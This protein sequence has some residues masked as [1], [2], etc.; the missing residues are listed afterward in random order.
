MMRGMTNS[1]IMNESIRN[2]NEAVAKGKADGHITSS[3]MDEIIHS[4]N[5]PIHGK[6]PKAAEF[7]FMSVGAD[8]S[9][10]ENAVLEEAE[11]SIGESD[12]FN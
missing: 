2:I 4:V 12:W 3:D 9:G 7:K 1:V 10:A 8:F 5:S 6:H 11:E